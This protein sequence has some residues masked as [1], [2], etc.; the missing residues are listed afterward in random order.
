MKRAR[1]LPILL[2]ASVVLSA[3]TNAR[4]QQT[5]PSPTPV[6]TATTSASGAAA[7]N[8]S[9]N[10]QPAAVASPATP[11]RLPV[12]VVTATRLEQPITEIGTSVNV[13]EA[14]EMQAQKLV[15]VGD[16]LREIPGVEVSQ[17]GSPGTLT[18]VQIRGGTSEQTLVLVDGVEVND[19]TD[20]E[21][22]MANLTTDNLNR[23]EVLRGSGGALY[24][25][26][27]VGGVINLISEEG[28]G[29]PK[30]SLLSE[31]GNRATERQML[32]A[33]GSEGSLG[34]SGS[35]SY[36]STEG[37]RPINDSS[38][39]LSGNLRLDEHL[40]D[41]TVVRFFARYSR[42][43][44]SLVNF[45]IASGFPIDPTAH[46]RDEFMLFKG[47]LEHR[48]GDNLLVRWN[49]AFVRSEIRI[50]ATPYSGNSSS[51]SDYI[52][53]E[54]R[55]STLDAVYNWGSGF[56]SLIGFDFK[57]RWA[58]SGDNSNYPEFDY[59]SITVFRHRRQE[60]AGY[61]QQ[62][63]SF[64]NGRLLA[65]AGF[66]VDGNSDFGKEVSPAWSV[67]IPIE[68]IDTTLRGSYSEGFRAPSFN[69]LYY[70]GYGNPKLGPE[71]SSEYDGGFTKRFGELASFTATY[72]SR[73]VHNLIVP[74]PCQYSPTTCPDGSRAG[75]VGRVDTQGVELEP[76]LGPW[77]DFRLSG[78]FSLLDET[79]SSSSPN[80]RPLRVPKKSA[81]AIAQYEHSGMFRY[82]DKV[83]ANL[84]YTFVGDR[85]D[86]EPSGTIQ[87]HDAYHLFNA[88]LS[89]ST[90]ISWRAIQNEEF[91]VRVQ[92][93]FDRNYSQ[94]FGFKS[95]PINFVA[96]VKLDFG[97]PQAPSLK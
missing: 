65:T 52:P 10:Q 60:Y 84:V 1:V 68:E 69:D 87:S 62:E 43:N 31:G 74:V 28:E 88:V 19:V 96:G 5:S 3:W 49:A 33:N 30:F 70:P 63:G 2:F 36:F 8:S 94:A 9:S 26:H 95:P 66:R 42:S 71:L 97:A 25:S 16:A 51:E 14:P 37:F 38:D 77:R 91:Y 85:D 22:D 12:L 76:T 61:V 6:P 57:D 48:F 35:L 15:T 75:N 32:T 39:N 4:P 44:V 67:A 27:A 59:T 72:F 89:Y 93:L 54:N 13:I 24:G 92:N 7:Q 45:A 40:S 82:G 90:G 58:R 41:D 81:A 50:N 17:S 86:V 53:E 73:R 55:S 23:I 11:G 79:H 21:F 46:Q 56:R 83:N 29:A 78:N 80:N 34:Y 47:A 18:G 64:F 20:G